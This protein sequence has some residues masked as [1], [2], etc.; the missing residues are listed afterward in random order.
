MWIDLDRFFRAVTA[1]EIRPPILA[2]KEVALR[3]DQMRFL[4]IKEVSELNKNYL[5]TK[6]GSIKNHNTRLVLNNK[7]L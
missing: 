7:K 4:N 3:S 1:R 6:I 2:P 5:N